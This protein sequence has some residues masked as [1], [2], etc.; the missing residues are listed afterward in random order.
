MLPSPVGPYVFQSVAGT[1][2]YSVVYK[3]IH[4]P[5]GKNVAIKVIEK[6][7]LN[8]AVFNREL[9]ILK[10]LDF[11]LCN[12]FIEHIEDEQCHYLVLEHVNGKS[13]HTMLARS[14]HP[15][16]ERTAR[17]YFCQL[18][19]CI[20]YL[21]VEL[22]FAHR[23]IKL[24]NIMVDEFGN[25]RLIDF[26]FANMYKSESGVLST[27]CGSPYFSP[28]EMMR[29]MPYTTT[30][31][32]WSAGVCLYYM[33]TGKPPFKD[34]NI[35]KVAEKIISEDPIFP[36]DMSSELQ[37]LLSK[38]LAK[39]P[40]ER[41]T[42][43]RVRE[44]PWFV[45]Y[46]YSSMM[47]FNFGSDRAWRNPPMTRGEPDPEVLAEMASMGIEYTDDCPAYRILKKEKVV[48]EMSILAENAEKDALPGENPDRRDVYKLA[49]QLTTRNRK[50]TASLSRLGQGTIPHRV[51]RVSDCTGLKATA[52]Q[53]LSG[54]HVRYR[55]GFLSS[56]M[57]D[58]VSTVY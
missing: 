15:F 32:V 44:H 36:N 34:T 19:A 13:I 43:Q 54:V 55:A 12:K 24:E 4:T 28:P 30:A 35:R 25:I 29:N 42:I 26:G 50:S 3:A 11:P 9:S 57:S 10:Q 45:S 52:M 22:N 51:R 5:T 40:F 33:V 6:E 41:L 48:R 18:I 38:M 8:V 31:D 53:V 49:A 1:G 7:N 47:H 14:K 21:Q 58:S 17:K 27:A 2:S 37:D 56:D 20:Q 46:F 16:S 39:D 23:D